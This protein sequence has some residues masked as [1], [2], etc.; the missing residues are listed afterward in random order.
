MRKIHLLTL[1]LIALAATPARAAYFPADAIDGPSADIVRVGDVDLTR[2][3]SGAVVYV[4]QIAG[5]NHVFAARLS[6]GGWQPPEQLDVG[7]DAPGSQ[8]VVGASDGGRLVAAFVSGGQLF[9]TSR[10]LGATTWSAPVAIAPAAADPSLDLSI[11]GV[12][13]V[14]FT[15][16]GD[17]RGAR[18]AR[19]ATAWAPLDQPLDIDPAHTAGRSDV[20]L[21][22]DG[23]AVTAFV[24]GDK[25]IARR[26]FGTQV[27]QVPQVLNVDQVAGHVGGPADSPD[28]DIEDDSSFAWMV[29][30][31]NFDD[32]PRVL[33]RRLLGSTFD[34][35]IVVDA[36]VSGS[37][38]RIDISGRGE[39]VTAVAMPD[40]GVVANLLHLDL[41]GTAARIDTPPAA[42]A[43]APVPT[44]GENG[45]ATVSWLAAATPADAVTVHGRHWLI[46]QQSRAYP[47]PEPDT[48]MSNP[49]FGAVDSGAGMDASADRTGDV[50]TAFVQGQGADRRLVV[51]AYDRVPG[52]FIAMSGSGYRSLKAKPLK[53]SP[54]VDIW[55]TVTYTVLVDGK[56]AGQTTATKFTPPKRVRDGK[57]RW[58]VVATD[59]RGQQAATKTGTL[60]VDETPPSLHVTVSRS[61]TT[62]TVS[63][64]AHDKRSGLRSIVTSFGD[65]TRVEG[66]RAAHRYRS[67]GSFRLTVRATDQAGARRLSTRTIRIKK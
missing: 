14:T 25:V 51:A 46:D 21:S 42:I 64:R 20:A 16:A 28:I 18:L 19:D 60:R 26:M 61:G 5:V 63:S 32:H 11:N 47:L 1:L 24:E 52:R 17:V 50:A 7:L 4:K 27:S 49:A 48:L 9:G 34:P 22:A 3:G 39:G 33:A 44:I 2:D 38:P 62:V 45:S 23:T 31:Q 43:P 55:E 15:A 29:F 36:E 37:A 66:A 35:A 53:W 67:S 10:V 6:G 13:Y 12:A 8:P 41:F 54:S 57:H 40:N 58:S 59:A 56:S 65:G 30:R